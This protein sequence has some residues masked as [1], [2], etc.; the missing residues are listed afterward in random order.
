MIMEQNQPHRAL[1][2]LLSQVP[3]LARGS[4]IL[5]LFCFITLL[6]SSPVLAQSCPLC[7][8]ALI[9]QA[10]STIRAINFGILTLLF[11]PIILMSCIL[12]TAFRRDHK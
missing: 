1:K 2:N 8:T 6:L 10:E 7:K 5:L 11:P 9:G 3:R 12:I 4:G